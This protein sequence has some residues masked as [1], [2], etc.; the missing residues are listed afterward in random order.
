MANHTEKKNE[1]SKNHDLNNNPV[2]VISSVENKNNEQLHVDKDKLGG[3]LPS[4][5]NSKKGNI[6]RM[7]CDSYMVK[8]SSSSSCSDLTSKCF[9][10]SN[11]TF[12]NDSNSKNFNKKKINETENDIKENICSVKHKT[13]STKKGRT[14]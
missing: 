10:N 4:N 14:S 6:E 9:T 7:S 11:K 1:T 5:D 12:Q 13:Q 2:I 8:S 3:D